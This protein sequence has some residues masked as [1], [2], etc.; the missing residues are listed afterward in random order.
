MIHLVLPDTE[1]GRSLAHALQLNGCAQI[2]E[3]DSSLQLSAV[4]DRMRHALDCLKQEDLLIHKYDYI[5]IMRYINEEHIKDTGLFF[6]SVNSFHDYMTIYM[7][8]QQVAGVSTLSQYY[9]CGNGRF[10]EWTFSDTKDA[11]ERLRRI[12]VARRF[13]AIFVKGC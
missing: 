13:A 8:H 5:W 10:P 1:A 4:D 12:N 3:S 6:C 11:S 2:V 9:S 7:G